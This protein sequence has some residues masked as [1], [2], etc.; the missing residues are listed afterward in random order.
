MTNQRIN[1]DQFPATMHHLII[2]LDKILL[3]K[4]PDTQLIAVDRVGNYRHVKP[5]QLV[6]RTYEISNVKIYPARNQPMVTYDAEVRNKN[7][8]ELDTICGI[9]A[10]SWA[11]ELGKKEFRLNITDQ[12]N[13]SYKEFNQYLKQNFKGVEF[14]GVAIEFSREQWEKHSQVNNLINLYHLTQ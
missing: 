5:K 12:A 11:V 8:K 14:T 4:Q 10:D 1:Y 9:F 6:E 13:K 7:N 3:N 2:Y